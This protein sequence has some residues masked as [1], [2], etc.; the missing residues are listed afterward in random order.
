MGAQI[1]LI[2]GGLAVDS[3][4]TDSA[5]VA[6]FTMARGQYTFQVSWQEVPVGSLV[7]NATANVSE[8]TPVRIT[9]SVYYP[10]F[11]AQDANGAPL[12]D[13]SILFLH[14]NGSK[15]GP[16]RTNATGDV[17]LS[18]VPAGTYGLEVAW[19]GVDVFTGTESVNSNSVIT[20]TTAVY[21]LTVTAKAGN[22][23]VLPGAFVSV[24]DSTGLVFDAGVTGS[25]GSVVLRLPAGNYTIEAH[26]ITE[27]LGTLY[28]SGVRTQSVSLTGSTSATVTFSDFPIPFTST[29]AFLFGVVYGVTV[30]VLL[31]AFYLMWRR[32]ARGK[33]AQATEPTQAPEKK[34]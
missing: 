22:G 29:L 23:Q 11:E 27:Q 34:E 18:Q 4:V 25:D 1:S 7:Y 10:V 16:Y 9:T 26:Y 15:I 12:A 17:L 30:A 33:S 6:N 3:Q 20:F 8:N 28:D 14:P 19:R 13:A 31:A 32:G 24:V 5:A 2:S 21:E